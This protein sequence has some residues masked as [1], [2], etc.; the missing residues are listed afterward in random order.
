MNHVCTTSRH[1]QWVFCFVTAYRNRVRQCFSELTASRLLFYSF[2]FSHFF[3]GWCWCYR[4]LVVATQL[5]AAGRKEV[6]TRQWAAATSREGCACMCWNTLLSWLVCLSTL[7]SYRVH[8]MCFSAERL[9]KRV[10]VKIWG[11]SCHR[12]KQC[13]REARPV[14]ENSLLQPT[15]NSSLLPA[16]HSGTAYWKGQPQN[17]SEALLSNKKAVHC[18]FSGS[19]SK[20]LVFKNGCTDV[21]KAVWGTKDTSSLWHQKDR[22]ISFVM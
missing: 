5:S 13:L 22:K 18:Y 6:M 3:W 2:L 17:D 10:W 4:K 12:D 8:K 20:L 14:L 16:L 19:F 11:G 21:V 1:S 7:K 9:G 15:H